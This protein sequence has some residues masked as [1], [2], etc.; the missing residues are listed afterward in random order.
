MRWLLLIGIIALIGVNI[1]RQPRDEID[2][3]LEEF[4]K[5]L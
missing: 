1:R 3:R 2:R 5:G 4:R